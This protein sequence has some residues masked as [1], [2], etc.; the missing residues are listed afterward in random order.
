MTVL[1]RPFIHVCLN[2]YE[3]ALLLKK[4]WKMIRQSRNGFLSFYKS[5]LRGI[6]ITQ[7]L[8]VEVAQVETLAQV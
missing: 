3:T 5:S 1:E 4:H 6:L 2:H 8:I 7:I